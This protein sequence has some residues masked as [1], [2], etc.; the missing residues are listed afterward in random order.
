MI[1]WLIFG[2]V[3]GVVGAV[4]TLVWW[5]IGDNWADEEHR[6]FREGLN[7]DAE[8]GATVIR[9]FGAKDDAR[10]PSTSEPT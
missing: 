2:I 8:A 10:D 4:L 5:R 1:G 9:G 3:L 7:D 6:R